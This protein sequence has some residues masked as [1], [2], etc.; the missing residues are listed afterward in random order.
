MEPSSWSVP[1]Q[2][3]TLRALKPPAS[4]Q[5]EYSDSLT[6]GLRLRVGKRTKTFVVL[7]TIDGKRERITIG[8]YPA[9][10]LRK[11]RERVRELAAEKTLGL[12]KPKSGADWAD[13]VEEYL[14]GKREKNKAST[15]AEKERL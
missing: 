4:G 14:A 9:V 12:T 2:D 3:A 6:P 5:V 13:C 7:R 1:F 10:T 11:A 8:Q 15:I